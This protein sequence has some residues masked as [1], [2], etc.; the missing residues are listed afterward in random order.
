MLTRIKG[1]LKVERFAIIEK[2]KTLNEIRKIFKG[3]ES[4]FLIL[5]NH[6]GI[7]LSTSNKKS[8]DTNTGYVQYDINGWRALIGLT[9]VLDIILPE[10]LPLRPPNLKIADQMAQGDIIKFST[11]F[12]TLAIIEY[13]IENEQVDEIE[14]TDE[15]I[16]I[17][18]I[19]RL[20]SLQEYANMAGDKSE[21]AK[22]VSWSYPQLFKK[23]DFLQL[24]DNRLASIKG[25]HLKDLTGLTRFLE[26]YTKKEGFIISREKFRQIVLENVDGDAAD[27]LLESVIFQKG[28]TLVQSPIVPLD[29]NNLLVVIWIISESMFFDAWLKPLLDD[30]NVQGSYSSAIGVLFEDYLEEQI[31]DVAD[32][33]LK[34]EEIKLTE[35]KGL[36][37]LDSLKKKGK[38]EIDLIATKNG[39]ALIIS[40]KGGR[41]ELPKSS[42]FQRYLVLSTREI[43]MKISENEEDALEIERVAKFLYANEIIKKELGIINMEIV[44]VLCSASVQPISFPS[45]RA[46]FNIKSDVVFMTPRGIKKMILDF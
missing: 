33:V 11:L 29:D 44:P 43:T 39:K 20:N 18:D 40:C 38:L 10:I 24:V 8:V 6:I 13:I 1:R 30:F 42:L 34:R 12:P 2:D 14:V 5:A 21:V 16:N 4:E 3:R 9:N 32:K 26:E 31:R 25:F 22:F 41:R 35:N 37:G 46:D 27:R 36:V 23:P 15:G 19:K 7:I 28:R 17:L 45:I